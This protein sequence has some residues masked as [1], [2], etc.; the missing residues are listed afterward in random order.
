MH[1][2]SMGVKRSLRRRSWRW[3]QPPRHS[4]KITS[5]PN[6]IRKSTSSLQDLHNHNRWLCLRHPPS[7]CTRRPE[8]QER[9]SCTAE[10]LLDSFSL[11][12]CQSETSFVAGDVRVEWQPS[13]GKKK[14]PKQKS[15]IGENVADFLLF[16]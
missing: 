15:C 13:R 11:Y 5:P 12:V 8:E 9:S 16:V 14:I 7:L 6:S 1:Y 3:C 4:D 2:F 10:D